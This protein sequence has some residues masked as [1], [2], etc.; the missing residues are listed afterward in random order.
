MER[1]AY[2]KVFVAYLSLSCNHC[3]KPACAEACPAKAITKRNEDGIVVV[4]REACLGRDACGSPC[5]EACPYRVP[6]F[7][8]KQDAKMQMC[9]FCLDRLKEKRRPIC[10][11]ACPVRALDAG[12]LDELRAAYGDVRNV[13]G[14]LYSEETRPSIIL[15]PRYD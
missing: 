1:G 7:D 6:Q 3:S 13:E 4:D 10:V 12:S 11:D 2:P 8:E 9:H 14:F 15:R 5:K